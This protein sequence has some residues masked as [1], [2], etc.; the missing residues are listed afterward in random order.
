MKIAAEDLRYR[1]DYLKDLVALAKAAYLKD[2]YTQEELEGYLLYYGMQYERV[3][4][5]SALEQLRK[6]PKPKRAG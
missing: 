1:Y 5:L 2:V 6:L 3:K 4:A